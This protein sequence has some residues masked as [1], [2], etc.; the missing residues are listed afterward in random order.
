MISFNELVNVGYP[1][2]VNAI[3]SWILTVV[4]D[5][6]KELDFL[7]FV[8]CSDAYL[9]KI[10]QDF[11]NHDYFT[12]IITFDYD[13]KV[14]SSDVYISVERVRDNAVGLNVSFHQEL[15]RVMV[16]GVLHLCGFTDKSE[17]ESQRMREMEDYYLELFVSRET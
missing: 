13:E 4:Q 6:K 3:Q 16:H 5:Q 14:V 9:L 17:V 12:D 11:L 15:M 1:L 2:D 8:F 7:N 10:N